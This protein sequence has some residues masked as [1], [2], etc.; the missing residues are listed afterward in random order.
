MPRK[1][2]VLLMEFSREIDR[3]I[4]TVKNRWLQIKG[5]Q[6]GFEG[7]FDFDYSYDQLLG[8]WAKLFVKDDVASYDNFIGAI[9]SELNHRTTENLE[10]V[11]RRVREDLRDSLTHALD[12]L[13]TRTS[14]LHS[15]LHPSQF[16][17]SVT[18][19]RTNIQNELETIAGWFE[20]VEQATLP[21]FE[22]EHL[23]DTTIEMVRKCYPSHSLS[24][25]LEIQGGLRCQGSV[26]VSFIDIMFI[27]LEN[28]AKHSTRDG[29]DTIVPMIAVNAVDGRFLLEVTNE[30]PESVD[31]PWL[32]GRLEQLREE[33]KPGVS[34]RFVRAEGGSGYYKLLKIIRHDLGRDVYDVCF[35]ISTDNRF[36][37]SI[38]MPIEGITI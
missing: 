37:T 23:V 25:R 12:T 3:I 31:I 10:R 34:D 9:F 17:A 11:Q 38:Q 30:I 27:I 2:N 29:T 24:P 35:H 16:A 33:G 15:A 8:L 5:E 1:A 6:N 22:F 28:V 19:C 4:D 20:N 7:M 18:R 32:R 21:D 14:E 13:L 26:F 36:V